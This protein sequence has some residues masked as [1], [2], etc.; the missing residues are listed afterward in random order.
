MDQCP[1]EALQRIKKVRHPTFIYEVLRQKLEELK[2][3]SHIL[4]LMNSIPADL[5]AR[6]LFLTS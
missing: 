1:K 4:S 2:I 6:I 5:S 3:K